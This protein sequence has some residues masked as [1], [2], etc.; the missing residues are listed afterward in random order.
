MNE[1]QF[2]F[3]RVVLPDGSTTVVCAKPGQTIRAV[4]GKLC[5]KRGLSIAAVDVFML[6]ADKVTSSKTTSLKTS[7]LS[8]HIFSMV[9]FT[10]IYL[11][12]YIKTNRKV[13]LEEHFILIF[14][15]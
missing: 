9:F 8:E 10:N 15:V 3:C 12:G 4:L 11:P 1:G 14:E 13:F 5:E 2:K 6:G 7:S